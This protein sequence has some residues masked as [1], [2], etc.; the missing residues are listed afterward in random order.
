MTEQFIKLWKSKQFE[1]FVCNHVT[2]TESQDLFTENESGSGKPTKSRSMQNNYLFGLVLSPVYIFAQQNKA[3]ASFEK[4]AELI[5]QLIKNR[6]MTVAFV[7]E[8]CMSLLRLEWNQVL[9]FMQA[10]LAEKRQQKTSFK[11]NKFSFCF[12]HFF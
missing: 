3:R 9:L 7:N 4:L 6:L 5:T 11:S 2:A 8:Q 1:L 10:N 12:F